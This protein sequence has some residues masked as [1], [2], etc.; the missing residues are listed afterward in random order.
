MMSDS[1]FTIHNSQ[2]KSG[3][4]VR[5]AFLLCIVLCALRIPAFAQKKQESK[6]ILTRIEFLFDASQSMY[7]RWQSGPKIDIAK[8]LMSSIL[9]S[10]RYVDNIELALRVYGHQKQFPPQDCDDSRLEVPFT[11]GNMSTIQEVLKNVVP[12]GTTPIAKS[13]E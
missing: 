5:H 12:R 3:S 13:L 9:D 4:I 11:K 8:K 1:Q 10:L 7:G 6:P 2:L